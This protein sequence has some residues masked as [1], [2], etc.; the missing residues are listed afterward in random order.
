MSLSD[1]AWAEIDLDALRQNLLICQ[2]VAGKSALWPVLKANAYGHGA[3]ECA[4]IYQGL[5][6][7]L[8]GVGDSSEALQLRHAGIQTRLLIL[9]TAIDSEIAPLVNRGRR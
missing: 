9:G 4:R 8:I 5:K 1:R 2:N 3:I 6:V 7:P